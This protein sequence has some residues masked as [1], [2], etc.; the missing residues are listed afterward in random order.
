MYCVSSE[1]SSYT[2]LVAGH[3]NSS[4]LMRCGGMQMSVCQRSERARMFLYLKYIGVPSYVPIPTS[5]YT[6]TYRVYSCRGRHTWIP[7][8]SAE[9]MA[10][11][12]L[13]TGA[14]RIELIRES[15]YYIIKQNLHSR[16][17]SDSSDASDRQISIFRWID[18]TDGFLLVVFQSMTL[19]PQHRAISSVVAE[20][21][22]R[23]P[24]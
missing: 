2:S 6:S 10:E 24:I 1:I 18:C 5:S 16:Q 11:R 17:T 21:A 20:I 12:N 23:I 22:R 15:T 19:T 14:G 9:K 4:F 7:S 3:E 13:L 8:N